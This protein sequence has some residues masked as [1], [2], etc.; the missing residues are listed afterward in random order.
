MFSRNMPTYT[1]IQKKKIKHIDC[2]LVGN[3]KAHKLTLSAFR[4]ASEMSGCAIILFCFSSLCFSNC[5]LGSNQITLENFTHKSWT[6]F[7]N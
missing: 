7:K 1:C 2:I 5:D 6:H 3:Y 4:K